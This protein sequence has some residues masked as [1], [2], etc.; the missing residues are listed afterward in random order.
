MRNTPRSRGFWLR[1]AGQ[2]YS[3]TGSRFFHGLRVCSG[4]AHPMSQVWHHPLPLASATRSAPSVAAL[5]AQCWPRSN[6]AHTQNSGDLKNVAPPYTSVRGSIMC[7]ISPFQRK[8]LCRTSTHPLQ[9]V[10]W[11]LGAR[12]RSSV[13]TGKLLLPWSR[14][15]YGVVQIQSTNG[16]IPF[17]RPESLSSLLHRE[18]EMQTLAQIKQ[19]P[20]DDS[21]SDSPLDGVDR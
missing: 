9:R 3:I 5:V 4:I 1:C 8:M 21:S 11:V 14:G 18:P 6:K 16:I 7:S 17:L 13:S 20:R 10:L 15:I 19:N 12:R 2:L